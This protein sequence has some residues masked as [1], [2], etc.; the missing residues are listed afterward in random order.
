[1]SGGNGGN[2]WWTSPEEAL[3]AR[4]ARERMPLGEIGRAM[5]AAGWP[6]RERTARAAKLRDLDVSLAGLIDEGEPA[7]PGDIEK[8]RRYAELGRTDEQAACLLSRTTAE[9]LALAKRHGIRLSAG[10]KHRARTVRVQTADEQFARAS[11]AERQQAARTALARARAAQ[12][13]RVEEATAHRLRGWRERVE[14][15]EALV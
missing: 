10:R 1:M 9:T 14:R 6:R 4:L 12:A 5:V 8:L 7:S 15:G 11:N 3:A 2:R 13:R